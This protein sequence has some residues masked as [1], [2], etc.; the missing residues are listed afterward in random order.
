MAIAGS[1]T[2]ISE[3]AR[4]AA[5]VDI[6]R[7]FGRAARLAGQETL[8]V[9]QAKATQP[10]QLLEIDHSTLSRLIERFERSALWIDE[11]NCFNRAMLG[12]H[13]LD[14]IMG[15][16]MGPADDVFAGA[17][18]I[19][20]NHVATRYTADFH[21]AL[22]VKVKHMDELQV[23]DM[24][25]GSPRMQP[26]SSWAPGEQA[27]VIRP[28]AGTGVNGR[29]DWV[30]PGYFDAAEDL[31]DRTWA[32]AESFGVRVRGLGAMPL[33]GSSSS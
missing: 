20:R 18:A 13:M 1:S 15:L 16:G 19:K 21:A 9:I 4:I 33:A 27:K 8:D 10:F 5:M 2:I 23:I 30:G 12:A 32:S 29:S 22:V 11:G 3:G 17:I 14:D 25:P 31:L 24:V 6:D 28:Y 7:V 26:L